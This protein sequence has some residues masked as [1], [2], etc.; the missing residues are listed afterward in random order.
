MFIR[1][2]DKTAFIWNNENISYNDLLRNINYYSTLLK[3]KNIQKAA[4]LSAN[5]P[6]WGY[7]F[8]AIWKNHSIAVPIDFLSKP[9]EIA[10][11]LKDCRPEVIFCSS[12]LVKVIDEVKTLIDYDIHC[13]VFEKEKYSA[14]DYEPE[15]LDI[16]DIH[17]T[18]VIVYTSGT[19][20][21][22]KG[23]MLS[24]DN[25]IANIDSVTNNIKIYN[26]ERNV[27]VLLPMHHI[28]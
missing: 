25:L 10:Y 26:S 5:R 6:E 19:T 4:I 27:M 11:I 17:S 18:A 21:S 28:L 2:S 23:V 8:Y 3:D 22:P 20:G 12:E 14:A 15:E 9:A 7:A 24:Y 13:I 1:K 16:P